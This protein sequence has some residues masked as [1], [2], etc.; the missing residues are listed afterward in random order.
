MTPDEG[1]L[2]SVGSQ[3]VVENTEINVFEKDG[4]ASTTN[5]SAAQDDT[6]AGSSEAGSASD[7]TSDLGQNDSFAQE[8]GGDFFGG[9]DSYV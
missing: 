7:S 1:T 2:I 3:P 8:D 4:P 5:P 6:A 9:D